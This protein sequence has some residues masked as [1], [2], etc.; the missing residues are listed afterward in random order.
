LNEQPFNPGL[1]WNKTGRAGMAPLYID[2]RPGQKYFVKLVNFSN[3]EDAVALLAQGGEG[4]EILVPFGVYEMRWCSGLQWYGEAD[5]FGPYESCAKAKERFVFK[6]EGTDPVGYTV[7]L[8]EQFNG[9]LASQ[10]I[11]PSAF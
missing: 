5:R 3:H 6:L 10:D 7:E 4:I 11:D 2:T 9:N 8:Y 1:L